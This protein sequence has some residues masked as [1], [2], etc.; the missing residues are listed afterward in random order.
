MPRRGDADFRRPFS[1]QFMLR[2]GGGIRWLNNLRQNLYP[3]MG[4]AHISAVPRLMLATEASYGH[5]LDE[6][7]EVALGY[8]VFSF[9]AVGMYHG[10]PH[11]CVAIEVDDDDKCL[12]HLIAEIHSLTSVQRT[13]FRPHITIRKGSPKLTY[14]AYF[15]DWMGFKRLRSSVAGLLNDYEVSSGRRPLSGRVIGLQVVQGDMIRASFP[16][17]P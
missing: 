9:E 16:F 15:G 7:A 6:I 3:G 12:E 11:G 5:L 13:R 1:I 8:A 14:F 2:R 10:K 17:G 4:P